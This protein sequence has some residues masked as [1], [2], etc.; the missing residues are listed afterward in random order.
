MVKISELEEVY[1]E[2]HKK[3]FQLYQ[4]AVKCFP[5]GVT[6]DGRHQSPFPIYA[7]SADGTKKWDVDGNE[8]IDY[9]MGH[10]SLLF[11]YNDKGILEKFQEETAKGFHMGASTELEIKWANYIKELVPSARKGLVRA[12]ACGSEAVQMGIRLA[13][14]YTGKDKI[15]VHLGAYH[16][17]QANTIYARRGPPVGIYNVRG[18]PDGIKRDVV[19]VPFNNLEKV[20]EAFKSGDVACFVHHCNAL[21]SREYL[22]GLRELT[23]RYGVVL[24]FDEV[25]SGF[26]YSAGGAQEYYGVT[27]DLTALGKIIGGGAPVGAVCGSEEIM[28][29]Y[30]FKDDYWNKFVRISVGGTW[31]AQPIC[32]AG[33]L[34]MLERIKKEKEKIYPKLYET[35]KRLTK[36]FNDAAEDLGVTAYAYGLP[37]DDPTTI[38]LNLFRDEVKDMHKYLWETGPKDFEGYKTKE[39]YNASRA[40]GYATYLSMINNGIFSYSGRGGSLCTKY[41]EEDL[42]KTEETFNLTLKVLKENNLLGALN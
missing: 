10:G 20:K 33:G 39:S 11:G 19:I 40:A 24:L 17:K 6:H 5:S 26:R 42:Q 9:V 16:G 2:R 22:E 25:V 8:Y 35:G 38:S 3:S 4:E 21:Y 36:S 32:T 18:I 30:S 27:P 41:S 31:N 14:I 23:K 13:R 37:V 12:T 34:A 28:E 15:I 7:K 29:F 1:R